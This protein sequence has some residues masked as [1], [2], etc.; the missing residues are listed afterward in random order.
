RMHFDQ[1]PE[2]PSELVPGI[3]AEIDDVLHWMLE[4]EPAKRPSS[5]E[6]LRLRVEALRQALGGAP[7]RTNPSSPMLSTSAFV[8]VGTDPPSLPAEAAPSA[9]T[10]PSPPK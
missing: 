10:P 4:K 9:A 8:E 2:R 5:A 1:P 7:R 6:E 3:P